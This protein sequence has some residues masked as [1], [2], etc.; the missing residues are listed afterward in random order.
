MIYTQSQKLELALS[1]DWHDRIFKKTVFERAN[2]M[3]RQIIRLTDEQQEDNVRQLSRLVTNYWRQPHWKSRSPIEFARSLRQLVADY[4]KGRID[5]NSMAA[6]LYTHLAG[7][8]R[9]MSVQVAV[10]GELEKLVNEAKQ[11]NFL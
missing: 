11:V 9:L 1:N 7:Q 10:V 2:T 3:Y 8:H 4:F 6:L 5:Q